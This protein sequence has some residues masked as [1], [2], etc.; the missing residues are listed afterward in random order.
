MGTYSVEVT[1]SAVS[2]LREIYDYIKLHLFE[3]DTATRQRERIRG[4][5]LGLSSMPKRHS[6]ISDGYLREQGIRFCPVDNYLIFYVVS[7]IERKVIVL[8]VLYS[9]RDWQVILSEDCS[10]L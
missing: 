2:D 6:L 5:I 3:P 4:A 8:R 1:D 7:E 10:A 9:R